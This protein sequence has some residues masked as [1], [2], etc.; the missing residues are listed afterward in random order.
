MS[1]SPSFSMLRT[2]ATFALMTRIPPAQSHIARH[3][4]AYL[5]SAFPA[6]PADRFHPSCPTAARGEAAIRS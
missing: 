1:A 4:V 3:V 6:H 2:S 5:L